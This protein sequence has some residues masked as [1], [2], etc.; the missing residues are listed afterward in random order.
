MIR[1]RL[2]ALAPQK[3]TRALVACAVVLSIV[4]PSAFADRNCTFAS[5]NPVNFGAYDVFAALPNNNGVGSLRISCNGGGGPFDVTLSTGQSNNYVSRLMRSGA[6]SLDYNLYTSAARSV[7]WGNGS[8]VSQTMHA[9]GNTT[10]TLS[11][12]GQIPAGQD[13]AVGIYSDS[14]TAIVNF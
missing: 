7:V 3:Q 6:N 13:A 11:I 4:S 1:H 2:R 5:A 8:G 12:F 9:A 14:I 10:T